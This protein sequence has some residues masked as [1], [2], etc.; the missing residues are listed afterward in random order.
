M[1]EYP[2][3]TSTA[4][5]RTSENMSPSPA[6]KAPADWIFLQPSILD[7]MHDSVVVTDVDGKITGCNHATFQI[8]GNAPQ[9]L[10]GQSVAVFYPPKDAGLADSTVMPALQKTH[11]FRG[12]VRKQTRSGNY[13][14]LHAS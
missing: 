4:S 3:I 13:I 2:Q 14:I 1:N 5:S 7:Q 12:E 10:V 11:E 9:D 8:F 6:S